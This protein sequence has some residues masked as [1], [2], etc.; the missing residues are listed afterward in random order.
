[1]QDRIDVIVV[2]RHLQLLL[3]FIAYWLLFIV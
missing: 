3:L 1:V 2:K